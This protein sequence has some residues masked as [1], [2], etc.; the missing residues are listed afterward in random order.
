MEFPEEDDVVYQQPV[1]EEPERRSVA[2]NESDPENSSVPAYL[3]WWS[4]PPENSIGGV[5]EPTRFQVVNWSW[6]WKVFRRNAAWQLEGWNPQESEWVS[7]F[8]GENLNNWLNISRVRN[9]SNA[10]EKVTLNVTN[11]APIDTWF[12]FTFGI[13]LRVKSYINRS[14]WY[15]YV[16]TYPANETENYTVFFNFSDVQPLIQ[17]GMVIAKHGVAIV[18]GREVFYFRLTQNMSR[19]PL[20]SGSSYEIDPEFGN[21]N[22]AAPGGSQDI[23]DDIAGGY[24]QMGGTAGTADSISANLYH[25]GS[26]KNCVGVLYDSDKDW[27]AT[28]NA[29]LVT[30]SGEKTFTF[31]GTVN[32]EASAWYYICVFG[33]GGSGLMELYYDTSGGNGLYIHTPAISYPT[34][35]DPFEAYQVVATYNPQIYCTYTLPNVAPTVESP[36]PANKSTDVSLNVGLFSVWINDSNAGDTIDWTIETS[37]NV[38]DNSGTDEGDGLKYNVISRLTPGVNY[39]VYVNATD[40]S[41]WTNKTFWFV[42]RDRITK[43]VLKN[44]GANVTVE[45]GA[46]NTAPELSSEGVTPSSGVASYT[47]FYFNVTWADDDGDDPTDGYLTV[48]VSRT[49]W[50]TNQSMNYISGSNT[51]GALYSYSTT[52]TAGSYSFQCWAS[53]GEDTNNTDSSPYPSVSAQSLTFSVTLSSPSSGQFDF[54]DWTLTL[55]GAGLTTEYNVSE[56]NQTGV[57]PALEITNTGNVPQNFTLMWLS[58]PGSG[59][60]M[61]YNTEDTAPNP[62]VN[63]IAVSPSET[64]IIT[65]LA[66]STAEEIW[67]WMDFVNVQAGS[68]N[69]D[70]RITSTIGE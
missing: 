38:G 31:S 54:R 46:G 24:F 19:Q 7:E 16:L 63:T 70:I 50:Y 18:D 35:P 48:N 33:D 20:Q 49:G 56:D 57:L 2:G 42:A 55:T 14:G 5:S 12:R 4:F 53:D 58:S 1:F 23:T 65:N 26:D 52:L 40:E 10:S 29:A 60:T 62:G 30:S 69:Q 28:T 13:D 45:P 51:T 41:L 25:T 44:F 39:T 6:F 3:Y 17:S 11:N 59:I 61:K 67:L 43:F 8:Q 9:E 36:S 34:V 21:T 68:S 22:I 64:Q 27:V 37:P 32:L 66:T 15:E 47:V